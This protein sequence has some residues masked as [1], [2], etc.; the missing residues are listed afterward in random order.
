VANRFLIVTGADEA[1]AAFASDL[2]TSLER[3]A[4]LGFAVGLLD[5]GL[6]SATREALARRVTAIVTPPWP[7]RPNPRFDTQIQA[8]AFATRPFLPD[9]FPGYDAY[10]WIDADSFVQNPR[11]IAILMAAAA[12]GLA[13]LVPTLDRSYSHTQT[14]RAWVLERYRMAFS[15]EIAL[16][17]STVPYI[18]SGVVSASVSSPLWRLWR[19]RFQLALDH[20]RGDR[21][22][23]QSI[24]NHV[25]YLENLPH[26]RLPSLCNWISHL[27]L[28]M[29][30]IAKGALVE[31]SYPRGGLYIVANSFN[32]KHKQRSFR[33][34]DG[35]GAIQCALT[36]E[37]VRDAIVEARKAS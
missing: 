26:H 4:R 17:L 7:F 5:Y 23:D 32:E 15:D 14:S 33:R 18:A 30:D 10:A 9:Y 20:W 19:E 16:R 22:C 29:I 21:L 11:G 28:P 34:A 1:Y 6:A 24:L 12:P 25:A 35:R 2:I 37:A 8:R 31:P 27:A 36:F 13:G 3:I